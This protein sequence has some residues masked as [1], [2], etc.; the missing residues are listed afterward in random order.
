MIL[1][2]AAGMD[3]EK[4]GIFFVESHAEFKALVLTYYIV[5]REAG[6]GIDK[7]RELRPFLY[8]CK[9]FGGFIEGIV[10]LGIHAEDSGAAL[11]A[12]LPYTALYCLL[13]R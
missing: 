6:A 1:Y 4:G 12:K 8:E 11:N 2:V 10:F 7:R 9:R 13:H 3:V 5:V